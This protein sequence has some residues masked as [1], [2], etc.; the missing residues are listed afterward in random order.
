[1]EPTDLKIL[2]CEIDVLTFVVDE[3]AYYFVAA[4]GRRGDI[5]RVQTLQP[6][7][8]DPDDYDFYMWVEATQGYFI[9]KQ[10]FLE[11]RPQTWQLIGEVVTERAGPTLFDE[12]SEVLSGR[13]REVDR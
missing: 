11:S 2:E 12:L 8:G 4:D 13:Y 1:M 3:G 10:K 6:T 5:I 7:I 9:L